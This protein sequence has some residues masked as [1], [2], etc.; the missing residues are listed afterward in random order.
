MIFTLVIIIAVP[1]YAHAHTARGLAARRKVMTDDAA[2]A[3]TRANR[4]VV[5]YSVRSVL[6][7]IVR[8]R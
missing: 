1:A 2:G 8:R 5:S 3:S 4:V 7:K 6:E